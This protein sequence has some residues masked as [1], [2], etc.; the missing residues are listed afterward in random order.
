MVVS[1]G[2]LKLPTLIEQIQIFRGFAHFK[3][4]EKQ[5]ANESGLVELSKLRQRRQ[6]FFDWNASY[7]TPVYVRMAVIISTLEL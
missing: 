1:E 2:G 7:F 3:D 4:G 5:S 6:K